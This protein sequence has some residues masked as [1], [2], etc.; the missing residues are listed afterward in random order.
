MSRGN[1]NARAVKRATDWS[2]TRSLRFVKNEAR[3]NEAGRYM[4]E[5]GISKREAFVALALAHKETRRW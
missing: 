2:Y 3:S 4:K 5:Q 1:K